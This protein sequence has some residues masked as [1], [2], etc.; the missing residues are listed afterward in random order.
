MG[1][2]FGSWL[3]YRKFRKKR[4]KGLMQ[5]SEDIK[6]P[7]FLFGGNYMSGTLVGGVFEPKRQEA[8]AKSKLFKHYDDRE[9][10][11]SGTSHYNSV[12]CKN[13]LDMDGNIVEI[14][15]HLIDPNNTIDYNDGGPLFSRKTEKGKPNK[16]Y[17]PGVSTSYFDGREIEYKLLELM[18]SRIYQDKQVEI[19]N[20]KSLVTDK[21]W[22]YA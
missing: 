7:D 11:A 10:I 6:S 20:W 16:H 4:F 21:P 13:P 12:E 18:K 9:G 19:F 5:L 14:C 15:A 1:N 3:E 8:M 2:L 17:Y 22:P